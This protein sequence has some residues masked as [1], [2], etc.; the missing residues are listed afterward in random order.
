MIRLESLLETIDGFDALR[1]RND[2]RVFLK[3]V[4]VICLTGSV[5]VPRS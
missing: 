3:K 1:E 4:L 5:K 2:P